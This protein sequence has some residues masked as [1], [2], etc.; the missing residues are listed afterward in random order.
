MKPIGCV[1][2]LKLTSQKLVV[3]NENKLAI[4]GRFVFPKCCLEKYFCS[5]F[6]YESNGMLVLGMGFFSSDKFRLFN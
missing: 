4:F 5:D 6:Q 3:V 1:R 2:L